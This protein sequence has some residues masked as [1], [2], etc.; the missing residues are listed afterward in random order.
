MGGRFDELEHVGA[1]NALGLEDVELLGQVVGLDLVVAAVG[2][3]DLGR[4]RG[5]VDDGAA[6]WAHLGGALKGAAAEL[7]DDDWLAVPLEITQ[8]L[9]VVGVVERGPVV[10]QAHQVKTGPVHVL[11]QARAVR[12]PATKAGSGQGACLGEQ[13]VQLLAEVR[14]P[15]PP[16]GR[17]AVAAVRRRQPPPRGGRASPR[18]RPRPGVAATTRAGPRSRPRPRCR[19]AGRCRCRRR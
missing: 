5:P 12:Q 10:V 8:V 18:P 15:G 4:V 2:A 6:G 7:D 11:P 19:R 9:G 14:E 16:L 1:V 17:S 13:A 3:R